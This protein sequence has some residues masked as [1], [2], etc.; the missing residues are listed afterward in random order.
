M[1]PEKTW[2]RVAGGLSSGRQNFRHCPC[3]PSRRRFHGLR[4]VVVEFSFGVLANQKMLVNGAK[5]NGLDGLAVFV[6]LG[7]V[8]RLAKIEDGLDA[9]GGGVTGA[10]E[11]FIGAGATH[12]VEDGGRGEF[13]CHPSGGLPSHQSVKM[14]IPPGGRLHGNQARRPR[15]DSP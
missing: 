1:L 4:C 15:A 3:G 8:P 9:G 5:P 7:H 13:A 2:W 12:A 6:N 10:D 14:G 11:E